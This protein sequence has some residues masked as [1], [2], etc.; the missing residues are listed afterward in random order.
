MNIAHFIDWYDEFKESP[1]KWINH[2]RQIAEDSCRHKTQD[3]DSN[4]ANRETNMR[5]S[6]YCE[7]CGFSEDD[8][9]PIINYSYPLYGLPDDEKIL[10]VV[11]ETCLTVM[12]NQDTGEV[13]LA[14]CGG[15]MDLSQSIAYAYILAGQRIPDEMALGVCT[16]P[17]LSLGI[18]EYKQT[19][20]QCKE[21]LA[22]MRRRGLEKIKRIQA[23][24]DKC[25][26]L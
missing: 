2:G 9:D 20:A 5:Y 15:G 22:D 23:A 24:L 11:K 16:Q 25:E 1:D 13:F 6:G 26:Q 19:M 21:N 14:L 7:Q 10:R 18:K 3:N 4:E 12:E 8:C 17:C